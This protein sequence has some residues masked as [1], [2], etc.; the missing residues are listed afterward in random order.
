MA[1]PGNAD[2]MDSMGELYFAM[3]RL[4]EALAKYKEAVELKSDYPSYFNIAY[5]YAFKEEYPQTRHWIDQYIRN[6]PS[7]R[8]Q[9]DA[10]RWKVFYDW[11]LGRIDEAYETI[12]QLG[13][14]AQSTG[15]SRNQASMAWIAGWITYYTGKYDKA[16]AY[17]HDRYAILMNRSPQGAPY[18]NTEYIFHKGLIDI[19]EGQLDSVELKLLRLKALIPK[20][21]SEDLDLMAYYQD[22]LQTEY[23]VEQRQYNKVIASHHKAFPEDLMLRYWRT[24]F[25]NAPFIRDGLAKAYVRNGDLE[26]AIIEYEKLITRDLSSNNRRLIYPVYHYR[27][28]KLYEDTGQRIKAIDAYGK[29]LEIWK[30]ADE[31]LDEVADARLRLAAVKKAL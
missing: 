4:D 15:E 22:F 2:P 7:P 23:L 18:Y 11:W 13:K 6:C 12:E 10:L 8:D 27:L 1:S 25:G 30:D 24:P 16:R 14:I 28:A 29:F 31:D 5:I 20:N 26:K 17:F 21:K 3:G 9:I 19:A